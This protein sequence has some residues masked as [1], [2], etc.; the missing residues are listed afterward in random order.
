MMWSCFEHRRGGQGVV[1]RLQ[2]G[3]HLL[4]VRR[5]EFLVFP[6]PDLFVTRRN[7]G[8]WW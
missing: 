8:T 3:T 7:I 4:V 6:R 1:V 5:D 2:E